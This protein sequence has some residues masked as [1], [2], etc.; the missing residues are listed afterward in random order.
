MY[1]A[2][3][4]HERYIHKRNSQ[5]YKRQYLLAISEIVENE[6]VDPKTANRIY[7]RRLNALKVCYA[8][9]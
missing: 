7:W 9:E 8:N 4:A 5:Y 6:G 2:K 1:D 3:K